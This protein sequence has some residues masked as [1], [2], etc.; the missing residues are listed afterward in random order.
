M[1]LLGGASAEKLRPI[2]ERTCR[3]VIGYDEGSIIAAATQCIV[4]NFT[5]EKAVKALTPYLAAATMD[6]VKAL[7]KNV[8]NADNLASGQPDERDSKSRKRRFKDF[9]DIIDT[10]IKQ[11]KFSDDEIK[12]LKTGVPLGSENQAIDVMAAAKKQIEN[13][14]KFLKNLSNKEISKVA[15]IQTLSKEGMAK[16]KRAEELQARITSALARKPGSLGVGGTGPSAVILGKDGQRVDAVTGDIIQFAKALPSTLANQNIQA[17]DAMKFEARQTAIAKEETKKEWTQEIEEDTSVFKDFRIAAK[18]TMRRPR[19]FAF[20]EQGKYVR[21][22]NQ[23]RLKEKMKTLKEKID[24][25]T[26]ETGIAQATALLAPRSRQEWELHVPEMEWWDSIVTTDDFKFDNLIQHPEQ[27]APPADAPPPDAI[28]LYLTKKE[29]KKMRRLNRKEV[30]KEEQEKIRLGLLPVPEPKVKLANMMRVLD[31][32]AVAD[33]TKVE[34]HVREQMAKRQ[35]KHEQ[36]NL[37]RKLTDEQKREKKIKKLQE[38]TT[39]GVKVSIYRIRSLKDAAKKFKIEMNS[40][41]LYMTGITILNPDCSVVIV[42]GGP[43][44]QRKFRRLM[45]NRIKWSEDTIEYEDGNYC[46]LVWEGETAEHCFGDMIFKL[47]TTEVAARDYFR[48]RKCEH[49]WDL[50]HSKATITKID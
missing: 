9:E 41:Q 33:P 43:K 7:W 18:S 46:H 27:K 35:K 6:F 29:R 38:D 40:K 30:Q 16:A 25:Q 3:E 22:A 5:R 42:E 13:R 2:A 12:K 28:G 19:K 37:A 47:C 44:S 48:D 32:A 24:T 4:Q 31:S 39:N 21:E 14:K 17:R 10:S 11:P 34:R 20:V 8:E 45:I 36:D 50:A 15:N 23:M 49:Y 1:S 26:R